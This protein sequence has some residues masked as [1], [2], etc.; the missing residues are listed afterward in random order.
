MW[1][2][3]FSIFTIILVAAVGYW[4]SLN[5][6]VRY[7]ILNPPDNEN[8]LFWTT[9]QRDAGFRALEYLDILPKRTISKSDEKTSNH[10]DNNEKNKPIELEP[11][12]PLAIPDEKIADYFKSQRIAALV[13]IHEGK[14][15]FEGYG[16]DFDADSKW[17]SFSVA[18][19]FTSTLVGAALKDGYI[20]SLQDKVTDYIPSM[21]G[22]AYDDVSIEQL[23]TMTSGVKWNEDYSDPQSDVSQFNFHQPDPGIDATASYMRKL[24]RASAPGA[25]WVYSTGETNLIGL[26]VSRATGKPLA[27][28]LSEKIWQHIG[29]EQNAS[30]ILGPSNHEISGCCIQATTRDFAR[31]GL[32]ILNGAKVGGEGATGSS[33]VPDN[34]FNLAT[35]KQADTGSEDMGYGYQWWTWEDGSFQGRGIFGQGIFIDPGKDLVIAVNSNWPVASSAEYNARKFAM[36]RDIQKAVTDSESN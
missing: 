36:Y 26:L 13:V 12:K 2:W 35:R 29:A 6:G 16:L 10:T 20:K 19:S 4:F 23:L 33:I 15:V 9:E 8:V 22:S 5:S 31:F 17:T 18:K 28:Y 14:L 24:P 27:D 21:R 7:L 25:N 3:L 30:W 32:F 1:K 34:W 11:G